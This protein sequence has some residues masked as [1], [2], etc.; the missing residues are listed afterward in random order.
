MII[1]NKQ[2]RDPN[3]GINTTTVWDYMKYYTDPEKDREGVLDIVTGFFSVTGLELLG[4]HFSPNN[5][6]R[7]VLAQMVADDQFQ[8][9]ILDLLNDD[10]GIE[11]ALHL[12]DAAKNALEF[13]RRDKVHVKAIINAFCHAKLYLFKDNHDPA[14]N[15][16]VQGSSNLTYAGLG[17]TPSSNVELNLADTGN[18]DTY[19]SLRSWFEEQWTS[20][21][22]EK[23]PEDREKPKG[24]QIDV[25]QYF[26]QEIE[27]I[28][29]KYTPEEIYYKIL[30]ELFNSDLDLDGGIEHR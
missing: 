12:S 9:H 6:Y 21:A 11:N 3:D 13:L 10:C 19:R 20:V 24:A 29:R 16:Y 28:F 1:D 25:K 7:M 15:Y 14:H 17:Y 5:E 2:D 4:K 26:I 8:D 30:F 22:K 27:K 23:M 18:S